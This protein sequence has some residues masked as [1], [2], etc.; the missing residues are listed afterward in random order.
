MRTLRSHNFALDNAAHVHYV[1]FP[2]VAV[3]CTLQGT[4]VCTCTRPPKCA[5]SC[6]LALC[7]FSSGIKIQ[8]YVYI[9]LSELEVFNIWWSWL[10][11]RSKAEIDYHLENAFISIFI[12]TVYSKTLYICFFAS[13]TNL[14]KMSFFHFIQYTDFI[15]TYRWWVALALKLNILHR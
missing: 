8:L 15:T 12:F 10:I 1:H 6:P 14:S 7:Q 5:L 4:T 3:E 9:R 13:A 11:L 2:V